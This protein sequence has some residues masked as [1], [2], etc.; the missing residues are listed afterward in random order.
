MSGAGLAALAAQ[1]REQ[2]TQFT[3]AISGSLGRLVFSL[4]YFVLLA[5]TLSIAEFGIFATVSATGVM[6]SRIVGFGFSSP[7][8]RIATVKPRLLGV[9]TAGFI[10]IAALSVPLF[11]AAAVGAHLLIFADLAPFAVVLTILCTEALV[12]R[13]AEVVITVVNGL[14]RFA[15]ASMLT[16][17]GTAMRAAAALAFSLA[18]DGTLAQ[19]A[20]Y[21]LIAN[22]ASLA[23]AV[24]VF[25]PRVRLRLVPG[26]YVRRM[27]DALAVSGAEMLFYLQM[28]LDKIVVLTFGGA[29]MAGI[30]AIIM[31]LVDLTAIPVRT[32]NMLLV[33]KLMRTPQWINRISR[34]AAIEIAIFAVSTAALL[35]AGL[36]LAI[37]PDI[38]GSNVATVAPFVILALAVPGFRNLVEYHAELL[39]A[40]GQT[41]IRAINLALLAG[42]KAVILIAILQQTATTGSLVSWLNA[43]FALLFAVSALLTHTALRQPPKRI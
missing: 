20:W 40:R 22:A 29:Q 26:L 3:A 31:R 27:S 38:L 18:G 39:Y 36:L 37:K 41:W 8:Y 25:Y 19:W 21:Y 6:L 24:L 16:I 13:S 15:R 5:N 4:A 34:R 1:Y 43:G 42:A 9:Y 23:I 32:F 12:W 33:Q 17:T 10:A 30:Y 7:L 14:Q 11:L 35:F 28:E 2:I